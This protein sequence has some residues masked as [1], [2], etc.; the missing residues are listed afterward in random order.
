[1]NNGGRDGANFWMRAKNQKQFRKFDP[2]QN[3]SGIPE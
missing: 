1:M 2:A 3:T